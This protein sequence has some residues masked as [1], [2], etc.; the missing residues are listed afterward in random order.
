MLAQDFYQSGSCA[1][2]DDIFNEDYDEYEPYDEKDFFSKKDQSCGAGRYGHD[3]AGRPGNKTKKKQ[4][5]TDAKN[6]YWRKHR[7]DISW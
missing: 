2:V 7:D 4:H 1:C 3:E 6:R 5:R